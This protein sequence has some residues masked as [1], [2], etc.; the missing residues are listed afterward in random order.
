MKKRFLRLMALTL[1]ASMGLSS[2]C[3]YAD[4]TGGGD[5]PV[6]NSQY[7]SLDFIKANMPDVPELRFNGTTKEEYIKWQSETKAKLMEIMGIKD[8]TKAEANPQ[9]V[10]RVDFDNY[11][12][13]KYTINTT[14]NLVMPYYVLRPKHNANGKA[15]IA[16]HG[17]GSD[18]KEG[19]VGNEREELKSSVE[20][21]H[22]TYADELLKKGYTVYVPDLLGAGERTLG[23]YKDNTAECND[24]NNALTSLGYSLQG[25]ILFENMVLS[26]IISNQNFS[27][28]DCIGFSGGGQSAL[29]LAV[30]SDKIDKTVV[31]GFFH[32]Y[33]DTIIYNNRCGCN[34]IPNM[35]KY[36][37]MGDIAALAADKEIYFETGK[38]DKLN[39]D[40]GLNGVN[41]QVNIANKAFKL[42]DKKVQLKVCDGA[43][44]WYSSW[45][46]KF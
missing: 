29:W 33:K 24:I 4:T 43:H 25:I 9:L 17:H 13:L 31:S 32:S 21:Y 44:Q 18:G 37:D 2:I 23:V 42:F 38:D 16:I 40:R 46:D 6:H 19:L 3:V 22:Y 15:A 7:N 11:T 27:E 5:T 12:R 41:E 26:D 28:I 36:V 39:G 34:F 20:K 14:S 45:M 30:M 35:W 1:S 10:E 8:L